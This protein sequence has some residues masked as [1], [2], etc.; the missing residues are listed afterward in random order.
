[1]T[2]WWRLR[3]QAYLVLGVLLFLI[4]FLGAFALSEAKRHAIEADVLLGA[5]YKATAILRQIETARA[6]ELRAAAKW[7]VT[8]D[9]AYENQAR[10]ERK[11][12]SDALERLRLN[13]LGDRGVADAI[14]R[15]VV[16]RRSE[17][18]IGGRP[19]P[20]FGEALREL[21]QLLGSARAEHAESL[22]VVAKDLD[23]V[24]VITFLF[25]IGVTTW[26]GVLL[27]YALLKPL[28][29]I[30]HAAQRIREGELSYRIKKFRGFAEL[31]DLRSEFN[32]MAAKLEELDNMK[33]DFL[34]TVSHELRTPLTSLKE[35]L[36]FL[37][38]KQ[39]ALPSHVTTRTI[40]VCN[41]SMKRLE[42]MI[43]NIL[44]HAKME[45]G[46]YSF[47]ERPKDFVTV[48]EAAING[49]K[50]IAER[51][52]RAMDLIINTTNCL[53]SFSTEGI[54]HA[55]ENLLLNAI[56]YGDPSHPIQIELSRIHQSPVPQLEVRVTNRGKGLQ[57]K[58]L[59]QDF[60]RFFRASNADG[61]KGVGLGL[62]VV[63]RIIEAH[64]GVVEVNSTN[65]VTTFWFRIPQRYESPAP[66]HALIE[67]LT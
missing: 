9:S 19:V 38:E 26:L 54:T 18:A 51:R 63:K 53:A 11:V 50:P 37:A 25:A 1:M 34:S 35:G 47:D 39:P 64:H 66:N 45:S 8:G 20:A 4:V 21:E 36:N 42:T 60:E 16:A 62:S 30:K 10:R 31:N 65:G 28:E 48:L 52:G 17:S 23:K 13:N 56:K 61:Q 46:F 33:G 5:N 3:T 43:Q 24:I 22:R 15:L 67:V 49:V 27:Y 41:Q 7:R 55:M 6:D 32:A 58:E 57:P 44:N 29:S 14:E 12:V 2:S 40:D 59:K